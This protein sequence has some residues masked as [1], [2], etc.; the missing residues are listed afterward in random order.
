MT[1]SENLEECWLDSDVRDKLLELQN[2]CIFMWVNTAGQPFGVTMSY[3][4]RDGSFW[5]TCA[6]A[7]KRVPAIEKSGYAAIA[8][9]S[10]GTEL[11][12]G[13]TASY[14]GPCTV[15]ED[16]ETM[17]WMFR[18]LSNALRPESKEGAQAFFEHLDTPNRVVLKLTPEYKLDFDSS[19]MWQHRPDAAPEGRLQ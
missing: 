7:R 14:R 9:T 6:K 17:I 2:E 18:E 5:L 1:D 16:K 12:T 3:I 11:G 10:K 19:K 4:W 8:I 15:H 13:K